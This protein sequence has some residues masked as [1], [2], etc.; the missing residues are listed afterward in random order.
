VFDIRRLFLGEVEL[1]SPPLP[2]LQLSTYSIMLKP[3]TLSQQSESNPANT[4]DATNEE[5][6]ILLKPRDPK[7]FLA[8]KLKFN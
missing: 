6:P 3:V 7:L 4:T 5:V 2:A 1:L 8:G